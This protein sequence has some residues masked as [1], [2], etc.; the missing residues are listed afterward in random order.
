M[1]MA[2]AGARQFETRMAARGPAMHHRVGHVGMKLKPE[3]C[4]EENACT[5]KSPPSA[6]NCA[7]C[8]SSNPS[9]C[10]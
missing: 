3:Q 9:R 7:P 4:P 2:R 10:Q 1:L 6:S 5:G 8:G